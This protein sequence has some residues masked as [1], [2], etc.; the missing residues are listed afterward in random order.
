MAGG[1]RDHSGGIAG[2]RGVLAEHSE[3]V[4]YDLLRLGRHIDDLGTPGL[5]WRDLWV[6]VTCAQP[7]TATFKALNPDWQ[8]T[9]ELELMRAQEYATRW[10]MWAKTEDAHKKPPRNVPKP[11]PLP[12]D[13]TAKEEVKPTA[14][15]IAEADEFLGWTKK[16]EAVEGG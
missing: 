6:I 3:A 7:D 5:S 14:M 8:H 4:E 16:R 9:V 1:V 11:L 15:T 13:P 2:L 10:Q 12:W